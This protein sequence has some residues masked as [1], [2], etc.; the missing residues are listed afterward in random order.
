MTELQPDSS[1][2]VASMS[3]IRRVSLVVIWS[4]PF[5]LAVGAYMAASYTESAAS[6]RTSVFDWPISEDVYGWLLLFVLLSGAWLI[7]EFISVT[8]RET[9]VTALQMDA[10]IST[11][12]ALL[13][14]GLAGWYIGKGTLQWWLVVPWVVSM[15]D[16][17]LA[18][19]L[20]INNAAQKPF[21][22]K[23]GTI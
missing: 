23:K 3:L 15:A 21:L 19:W 4:F 6:L 10:L 11:L 2:D 7:G 8:S 9:V 16:A 20:G 18:G 17:L 5:L 13:L 14:T 12:T 22:S 1:R